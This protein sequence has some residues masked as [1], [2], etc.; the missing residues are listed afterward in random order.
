VVAPIDL[1]DNAYYK[2]IRA[3]DGLKVIS[4]GTGSDNNTR[5]SYDDSGSYFDLDMSLLEPDSAYTIKFIYYL[6][7]QYAEQPEEFTF[8]VE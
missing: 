3:T 8:R 6:N 7:N 2:V 1:V 4:Y 5:L